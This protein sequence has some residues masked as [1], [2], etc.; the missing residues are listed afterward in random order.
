MINRVPERN[1]N[2]GFTNFAKWILLSL[3]LVTLTLRPG[4]LIERFEIRNLVFPLEQ[5][6]QAGIILS[7]SIMLLLGVISLNTKS[8]ISSD[9]IPSALLFQLLLQFYFLIRG[10]QNS[11]RQYS[12]ASELVLSL[13]TLYIFGLE[14]PSWIRDTRDFG[15]AIICLFIAGAI[16]S[17]LSVYQYW[18]D[19]SAALWEGRFLGISAHPNSAG[20]LLAISTPAGVYMIQRAW[21]EKRYFVFAVSMLIVLL[22]LILLVYAGSRTALLAVLVGAG[23]MFLPAAF[24]LAIGGA[25]VMLATAAIVS[26]ST[27]I[28]KYSQS[29]LR[30]LSTMNTRGDVWASLLREFQTAPIFGLGYSEASEGSFLRIAAIGGIVGLVI[31]FSGV[32]SL[33]G[34]LSRAYSRTIRARLLQMEAKCLIATI[35]VVATSGVFEGVLLDK[36]SFPIMSYFIAVSVCRR[37]RFVSL[38]NPTPHI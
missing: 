21:K 13:L 16:W 30:M 1:V 18:R 15:R 32:I 10:L 29:D 11:D 3:F 38:S 14:I 22:E 20:V 25:V 28:D 12:L 23:F 19:P 2:E 37:L 8:R 17:F 27:F 7:A 36:F 4:S 9:D 24:A 34:D 26:G 31:Y 33:I 35:V 6:R 5:I